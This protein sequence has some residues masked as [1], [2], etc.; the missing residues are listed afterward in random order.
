MVGSMLV[1]HISSNDRLISF[2]LMASREWV[3]TGFFTYKPFMPKQTEGKSF[4]LSSIP[5]Q[6]PNPMDISLWVT[7]AFLQV[8]I[9]HHVPQLT[10]CMW[11]NFL[12]PLNFITWSAESKWCQISLN[13]TVLSHVVLWLTLESKWPFWPS[14]YVMPWHAGSEHTFYAMKSELILP[15]PTEGECTAVVPD[16]QSCYTSLLRKWVVV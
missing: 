11:H 1:H 4:F 5:C 8:F 9:W 7:P 10:V 15:S 16:W 6:F 2:H 3:K 13:Y 14:S 12:I